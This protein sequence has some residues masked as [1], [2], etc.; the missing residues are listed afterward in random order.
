MKIEIQK[1]NKDEIDFF[2]ISIEP[3]MLTQNYQF[4]FSL[5]SQK[6]E[7]NDEMKNGLVK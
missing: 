1:I 3:L 5:A 4:F 2:F 7:R 6:S